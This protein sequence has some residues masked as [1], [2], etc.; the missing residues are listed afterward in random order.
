MN[1]VSDG[2][3]GPLDG[4]RGPAN[5]G[6]MRR[7]RIGRCNGTCRAD[8]GRGNLQRDDLVGGRK[9]IRGAGLELPHG[10]EIL[11]TFREIFDQE[12]SDVSRRLCDVVNDATLRRR[13]AV[14]VVEKVVEVE[15][16]NGFLLW[17]VT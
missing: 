2:I 11:C 7:R 17:A 15:A 1:N 6:R 5:A 9:A 3:H 13:Q 10:L 8:Y 4:F 14:E 12:C 16:R